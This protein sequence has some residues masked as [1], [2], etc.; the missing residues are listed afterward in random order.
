MKKST[1][2][3]FASGTVVLFV[4]TGLALSY[5]AT[6]LAFLAFGASMFVMAFGF[7][8]KGRAERKSK[9]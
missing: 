3:L 9:E 5:Q 7:I 2:L 1:A 6:D 4:L 8:V